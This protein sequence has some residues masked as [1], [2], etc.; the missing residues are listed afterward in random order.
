MSD[1][2]VRSSRRRGLLGGE[3]VGD[4]SIV[5]ERLAAMTP[6]QRRRV[7]GAAHR[8]RRELD[9][10]RRNGTA[11]SMELAEYRE[12]HLILKALE[13]LEVAT[14][15]GRAPSEIRAEIA[16]IDQKLV[17]L[18]RGPKATRSHEEA[19]RIK[20]LKARKRSLAEQ[21]RN[22]TQDPGRSPTRVRWTAKRIRSVISGGL[23][24]LGKGGR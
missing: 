9:E 2:P 14:P 18:Q 4:F 15:S 8:R 7:R 6:V 1:E 10:R 12:A 23:P 5:H 17:P 24:N 20:E 19:Q 3:A 13:D 22:E 21:L 16:V 11:A